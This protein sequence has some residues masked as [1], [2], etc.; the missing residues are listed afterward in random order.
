M[1]ADEALFALCAELCGCL[2]VG[3]CAQ[4]S[5]K[6]TQPCYW[7]SQGTG[8]TAAPQLWICGGATSVLLQLS[9]AK[10]QRVSCKFLDV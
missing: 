2:Y 5:G 1:R 3:T 4:L 8:A 10:L 6:C 9:T 7:L